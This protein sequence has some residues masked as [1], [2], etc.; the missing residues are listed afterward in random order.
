M[1]PFALVSAGMR[2]SCMYDCSAQACLSLQTCHF[3]SGSVSDVCPWSPR[4]QFYA[5]VTATPLYCVYVSSILCGFSHH[6]TIVLFLFYLSIHLLSLPLTP[7]TSAQNSRVWEKKINVRI[8]F[9]FIREI[10]PRWQSFETDRHKNRHIQDTQ[11]NN[12]TEWQLRRYIYHTTV[13]HICIFKCARC[14]CVIVN[15]KSKN[16][17]CIH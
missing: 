2:M 11:L 5:C 6:L 9:T 17:K 7:A 1:L 10:W 16:Q 13:G 14:L 3:Y 4:H 15:S 8:F 12:K